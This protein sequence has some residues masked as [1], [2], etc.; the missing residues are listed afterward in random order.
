MSKFHQLTFD[1]FCDADLTFTYNVESIA[2]SSLSDNIIA[3]LI[4]CLKNE[5]SINTMANSQ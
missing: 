1:S 3:F 4:D 5:K 2:M